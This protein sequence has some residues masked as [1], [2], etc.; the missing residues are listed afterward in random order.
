MIFWY[1]E[2][3]VL[4]ELGETEQGN[5]YMLN[6]TLDELL[7][8]GGFIHEYKYQ[9]CRIVSGAGHVHHHVCVRVKNL[10]FPSADIAL[11]RVSCSNIFK[12]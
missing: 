3:D 6:L 9:Y 2:N 1:Y 8:D 10:A 7:G 5:S 4:P 11:R 12:S